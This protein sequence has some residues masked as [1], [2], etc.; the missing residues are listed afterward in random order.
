MRVALILVCFAAL[1]F[2]QAGT[3]TI[4][5]TVTDQG[6]AVVPNASIE[7]RN[8]ETNAPYPTVTTET[9]A[10]TVLRLPPGP[11]TVTVTAPGFKKLTR[12]GI[13]VDAGQTLPLDL[14]LEVGATTESITVQADASLLKTESGDVAHNI[15]LEQLD[16]LPI[17]GIGTS[18]AGSLGIRNPY[19]SVVFLPGVNYSANFNMIVNGAPTNTGG[20][21]LEGLDFTN[22]VTP[23][24][25]FAIQQ[26]Q[27]SAD[28]VQEMALQTSTYAPEV[29]PAGGG[30]LNVTLK[31]GTN[32]FHGTAYEYFVNE[33]MNAG[34]PFSFNSGTPG[35]PSGGKFRP[36]NRRNDWGGTIG[37]P[38]WIPKVYNG[39]DKTFFFFSYERYK[40]DQALTFTDTLPNAQ[41]QAGNFSAISPNGGTG[42]NPNLG[43][44]ATPIATD[45]LGRPVFANE[46]FDPRSRTTAPNGQG[47]ADPFPN[48]II[49]KDRFSP[50]AVAIQNLLPPLSNGN[51]YANYNG[52]NLGERITD[53][54]SVK[55][56]Q[57]FGSRQ[58]LS[59]YFQRT[60]TNAQ[61]TSRTATP[62]ACPIC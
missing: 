20:Y 55:V 57:L 29:G 60:V 38:V 45:A 41:Y 39:K 58:K 56:D 23:P 4:T 17:L 28:A 33:F 1:M 54:P 61:F 53:I 34:D 35:N 11:Y 3:G 50:V 9:G 40:E 26:G 30:L 22:H 48:N 47:V 8:V 10:Y 59:F 6:G 36:S 52:Y 51:L 7:V 31:S 46:I 37:G 43:V 19:N 42:F 27:P 5:G 44:P 49:P 18:N 16:D 13:N 62:M 32:Q 15:T 14:S 21:R 12:T 2:G 24:N 25:N